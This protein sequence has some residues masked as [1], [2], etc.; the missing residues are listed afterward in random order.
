MG[1]MTSRH[2]TPDLLLHNVGGDTDLAA[3][4]AAAFLGDH[5]RL[6]SG[7]RQSVESGD[8]Q[9]IA[10]AAHALKGAVSYFTED[11]ARTQALRLEQMGRSGETTNAHACLAAL[12]TETANLVSALRAFYAAC[13]ALTGL[14]PGTPDTR[15]RPSAAPR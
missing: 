1:F 3:E 12:E 5:E 13:A 14:R 11:G 4:V 8:G 7:I 10:R 9:K 6:L 2:W 15:A